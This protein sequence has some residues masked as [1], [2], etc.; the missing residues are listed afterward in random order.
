MPYRA[1]KDQNRRPNGPQKGPIRVPKVDKKLIKKHVE[2]G[3]DFEVD[4]GSILIA[5]GVPNRTSLV[6]KMVFKN[7]HTLQTADFKI[8][9]VFQ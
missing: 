3:V 7:K 1:S 4:F 9:Y 6:T 2:T 5:F 8:I